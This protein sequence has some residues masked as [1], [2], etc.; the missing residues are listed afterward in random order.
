MIQVFQANTKYSGMYAP[1]CAFRGTR[2]GCDTTGYGHGYAFYSVFYMPIL[3]IIFLS[4][5]RANL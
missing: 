4:K 2:K 1:S 3:V 5:A